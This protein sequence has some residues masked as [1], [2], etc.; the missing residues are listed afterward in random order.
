MYFLFSYLM[1]L[2]RR[3]R[4]AHT[5]AAESSAGEAPAIATPG[6]AVRP[7]LTGRPDGPSAASRGPLSLL[8]HQA[9]YDLRISA[10]ELR[11]GAI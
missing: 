11:D 6:T 1:R 8:L 5:P 2:W 10:R 7:P 3:R 4:G 9:S